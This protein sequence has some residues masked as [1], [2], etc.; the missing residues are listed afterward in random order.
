[1]LRAA[2]TLALCVLCLLCLGVVMVNSAGLEVGREQA[3]VSLLSIATSRAAIYAALAMGAL[4]LASMVP[5]ERVLTAAR[6]APLLPLLTPLLVGICLL[7]YA[8]GVGRTVNGAVRWIGLTLPGIGDVTLQPSEIAKWGLPLALAGHCAARMGRVD[9][10]LTGLAPA[11]CC[12]AAVAA[13][14]ALEDLGTAVLVVAAGSIVLLAG[15]ARPTHFLLLAPLGL[16][17]AGVAVLARPYRLQR[18]ATFLDPFADPSDAGYQMIQSMAAVANGEVFGRGL[19][20]G[21]RKFGYLPEDRTDFLFAI[22]CEELGVAGAAVVIALLA[23]VLWSGW[24]IVRAERRVGPGLLGLGILA[25]FGLQAAMNLFVVTGLGPTKG[26][27]LPLLS[28]GG[29]GWIL[30]AASLG[31]LVGI[32]RRQGASAPEPE[33]SLAVPGHTASRSARALQAPRG[34]RVRGDR[35]AAGSLVVETREGVGLRAGGRG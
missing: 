5:I 15:G 7:V 9:R 19:G 32:Q 29:T 20:F 6:S 4:A 3:P 30:T 23:G 1:M 18:L 31:A 26:I 11:L 17:A 13:V 25:T 24:V 16:L 8:P 10:F 12:V 34:P 21:L 2:D 33:A 14:I 22:V 28:A 35:I 27:A